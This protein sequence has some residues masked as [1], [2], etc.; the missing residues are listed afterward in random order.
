MEVILMNYRKKISILLFA[1]FLTLNITACNS[2]IEKDNSKVENSKIIT[3]SSDLNSSEETS[4]I[5][6]L[7]SSVHT[8]EEESEVINKEESKSNNDSKKESSNEESSK[9]E[10]SNEEI[11]VESSIS[12]EEKVKIKEA[13]VNSNF[14]KYLE[15]YKESYNTKKVSAEMNNSYSQNN[16]TIKVNMSMSLYKVGDKEVSMS[17]TSGS[18]NGSSNLLPELTNNTLSILDGKYIYSVNTKDKTYYKF[19]SSIE[20]F[21]NNINDL[22]SILDVLEFVKSENGYEYFKPLTGIDSSVTEKLQSDRTKWNCTYTIYSPQ[23]GSGGDAYYT[24]LDSMTMVQQQFPLYKYLNADEAAA[25]ASWENLSDDDVDN[26]K[27][28]KYKKPDGSYDNL[29]NVSEKAEKV[30]K[31]I[32]AGFEYVQKAYPQITHVERFD[33]KKALNNRKNKLNHI[34]NEGV[35][36]LITGYSWLKVQFDWQQNDDGTWTLTESWMGV[37][38]TD[39]WDS[40]LYGATAWDFFIPTAQN[41]N[42]NNNNNNP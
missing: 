38:D 41:N 16:D 8:T 14:G 27:A 15:L 5:K 42:N 31:K 37:P 40:D 19:E 28:F 29:L 23:G 36:N 24:T 22:L 2:N 13:A 6:N 32:L 35:P 11:R 1:A 25:V 17:S 34:D 18:M 26:K 9:K 3:T 10:S 20:S 30:A 33:S 12:K 7:E 21:S 4:E 39:P